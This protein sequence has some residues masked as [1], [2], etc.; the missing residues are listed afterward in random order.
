[1]LTASLVV[2]PE[3]CEVQRLNLD[4]IVAYSDKTNGNPLAAFSSQRW[5][6]AVRR[7]FDPYFTGQT[8]LSDEGPAIDVCVKS[9]PKKLKLE[10]IRNVNRL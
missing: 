10:L 7:N 4:V 6:G 8:F 1:V 2:N 5:D 9:H 3:F